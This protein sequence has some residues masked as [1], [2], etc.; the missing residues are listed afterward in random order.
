MVAWLVDSVMVVSAVV[1]FMVAMAA[2]FMITMAADFAIATSAA[3]HFLAEGPTPMTTMTTT[4]TIRT[5]MAIHTMT[6]VVA[7]SF[8]DACTPLM[9]GAYAPLRCAVDGPQ[10][11]DAV[12]L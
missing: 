7:T 1:S 9:V 8:S 2:D 12:R 11:I 3:S 5:A 4:R 10:C 6:M